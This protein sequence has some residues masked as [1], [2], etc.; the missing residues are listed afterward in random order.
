MTTAISTLTQ[1]HT[2]KIGIESFVN[3]VVSEVEGGNYNP[4]QLKIFIKAIQKSLEEIEKRTNDLSF[5]EAAKH[6]EKSFELMGAAVQIT[7]L[8][9]KYDY[10][11]CNHPGLISVNDSIDKLTTEKKRLETFLKTVTKPMVICDESTGGESVEINPP[12]KTSS[13]GLKITIK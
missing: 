10:S 5:N 4:L 8:G 2:S 11:V 12:I 9:T 7:E 13:T 1:F 3:Q 6:S